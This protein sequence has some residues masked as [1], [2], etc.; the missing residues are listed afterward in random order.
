[1]ANETE[2]PTN[3]GTLESVLPKIPEHLLEF[4]T[5]VHQHM[6][7]NGVILTKER[8][9]IDWGYSEEE[10][11]SLISNKLVIAALKERDIDVTSEVKKANA[12]QGLENEQEE[13][14]G[15]KRARA[16]SPIQLL[17]ANSILDLI[18]QRSYKKKLQ[19]FGISTQ[20]YQRW[21]RDKNFVTYLNTMSE[22]L[23]GDAQY[24][25]SLALRD[26][27]AAGDLSAIKF[28]MEYTGR[29]DVRPESNGTTVNINNGGEPK[30]IKGLLVKVLEIVTEEC[31]GPTAFRIAERMK[32][33]TAIHAMAMDLSSN[34]VIPESAPMRE[35]DEETK[36]LLARTSSG[37]DV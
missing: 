16:L 2:A 3:K 4:V 27:V 29:H 13:T 33:A 15:E 9:F 34:I 30:D 28:Y 1:M 36:A 14:E 17:V 6:S 10:Y 25:A 11:N 35:M 18:D 7:M 21:L 12:L 32:E 37:G 20:T 24:E 26:K 31:D 23:L 22:N 19:D 8:A 5:V